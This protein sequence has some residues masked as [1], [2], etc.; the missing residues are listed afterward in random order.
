MRR[1]EDTYHYELYM[2]RICLEDR[3]LDSAMIWWQKMT[4]HTPENWVVWAEY[5]DIFARLCR[6]DEAVLY[7]KKAISLRPRPRFVDCED[8]I[9]QIC[10]IKGDIEGALQMK[11]QSLQ[12]ILEDWTTEGEAV[13][14]VQRE[15]RRL[16]S[17]LSGKPDT[18]GETL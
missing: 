8:A 10:L 12:I 5:G 9:A 15:I 3:D 13:H 18:R 14:M 7:Y 2:G 16:T 1:A 6:Y 17:Q 4:D 11:R